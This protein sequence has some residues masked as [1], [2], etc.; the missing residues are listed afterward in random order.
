[1]LNLEQHLVAALDERPP[2]L[3]LY[4]TYIHAWIPPFIKN[5]YIYPY[6]IISIDQKSRV[7]NTNGGAI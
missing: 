1:M 7:N 4:Y 6:T 2:S 3:L 5:I